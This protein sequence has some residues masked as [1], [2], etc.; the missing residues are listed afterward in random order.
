[1]DRA[2]STSHVQNRICI[3][4]LLLQYLDSL[5]R[6]QDE[7]F[8]F[9]TLGFEPHFLHYRQSNRPGADDQ[10]TALPRYLFSFTGTGKFCAMFMPRA[11]S[12]HL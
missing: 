8:D 10:L 7:Q 1:M 4:G 12:L 9:A 11:R 3:G 6:R 5:G 2:G